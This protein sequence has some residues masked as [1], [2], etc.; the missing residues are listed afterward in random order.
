MRNGTLLFGQAF[1]DCHFQWKISP[2]ARLCARTFS[3][4]RIADFGPN[5]IDQI[6]QQY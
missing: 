1:I 5:V 6:D 4:T 2:L 3:I